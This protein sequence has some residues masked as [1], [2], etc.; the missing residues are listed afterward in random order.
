MERY[1]PEGECKRW[2]KPQSKYI[3]VK[4]PAILN[5]YNAKMGGVDL[6][7]RVIGKYPMMY[8]TNKWTIRLFTILLILL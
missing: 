5:S 7:D 2:K 6:L 1:Q 8:R 3:E 4:Q